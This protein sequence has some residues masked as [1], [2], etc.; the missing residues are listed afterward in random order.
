MGLRIELKAPHA[1]SFW[2][3][4]PPGHAQCFL[5]LAAMGAVAT[6]N[7]RALQTRRFGGPNQAWRTPA[8]WEVGR[9]VPP[10]QCDRN[11]GAPGEGGQL[12]GLKA[13]SNHPEPTLDPTP[14]KANAG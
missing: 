10:T 9:R 13:R 12:G 6:G 14:T 3:A 4:G 5:Q 11:P 2:P 1:A 7:P 8:G